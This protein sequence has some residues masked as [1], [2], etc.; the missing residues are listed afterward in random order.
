MRLETEFHSLISEPGEIE[1]ICKTAMENWNATFSRKIFLENIEKYL[2]IAAAAEPTPAQTEE[3]THLLEYFKKVRKAGN[4]LRTT[5]LLF[6]VAHE[7]PENFHSFVWQ[8]GQLKDTFH[9][10]DKARPHGIILRNLLTSM[11]NW[12]E[13]TLRAD[14]VQNILPYIKPPLD[15]ARKLVE[16]TELPAEDF[17]HLRKKLRLFSITYTLAVKYGRTGRIKEM[18]DML[19]D[20]IDRL[21]DVNDVLVEKSVAGEKQYE[22]NVVTLDP[23][24]RAKIKE[25]LMGDQEESA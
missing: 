24:L 3:L 20:I 5:Y 10:P 6:D 12:G 17:H 7:E 25:L 18:K 8:L 1:Q 23:D 19:V 21:G 11:P 22:E 2:E 13:F 4:Y 15:R 16:H 14:E 9:H